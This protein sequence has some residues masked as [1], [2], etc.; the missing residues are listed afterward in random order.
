M[1]GLA[2]DFLPDVF[3]F[4]VLLVLGTF[5]IAIGLK[6]FRHSS[7]LPSKIRNIIS[8]FNVLIAIVGMSAVSFAVGL[9]VPGLKVPDE[10][11][12]SL[13]NPSRGNRMIPHIGTI[14][15]LIRSGVLF[16]RS[17]RFVNPPPP[18]AQD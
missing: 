8:D 10:F 18:A 12:V 15:L 13:F 3:L 17:G 9:D 1:S 14:S 2:C 5:V 6:A 7:Y 11:R 4:S 16:W